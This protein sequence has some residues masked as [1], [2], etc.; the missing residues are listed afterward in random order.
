MNDIKEIKFT[1]WMRQWLKQL[2]FILLWSAIWGYGFLLFQQYTFDMMAYRLYDK[3]NIYLFSTIIYIITNVV[4][5]SGLYA[6]D[7][8]QIISHDI[9]K[10]SGL[11]RALMPSL[12]ALPFFILPV[13]MYSLLAL[14]GIAG[15][16]MFRTGCTIYGNFFC[17]TQNIS[18]KKIETCYFPFLLLIAALFVTCGFLIQKTAYDVM[19][20][21][22][23]DW[24]YFYESLR[25]TLEGRWF[26]TNILHINFL[27]SRFCPG[28]AILLPYVAVFK[29]PYAFFL[30]SSLILS[31]GGIIVFLLGKRMGFSP[32][33]SMVFGLTYYL[34]PGFFNMNLCS[35]YS[36]HE[37]YF[38]IPTVLL[39][40]YFYEGKKYFCAAVFF[41]FSMTFQETVP[42][43]WLGFGLVAL[44][45]KQWRLAAVLI[46]TSLCCYI[47]I[48]RLAI[49][50]FRGE[51]FYTSMFRYKHLGES[52]VEIAL[53]PI[54]KPNAFWGAL[55]RPG[56]F[57]FLAVLLLPVFILTLNNP[58]GLVAGLIVFVFLC[59]ES[60]NQTQN[61]M[62]HYQTMI[63]T[64]IILNTMY[65]YRRLRERYISPCFKM[66][67]WGIEPQPKGETICSGLLLSM[68]IFA[69]L[70]FFCF[71]QIPGSR[72]EKS[73]I[74][75]MY[76]CRDKLKEIA[77][78]IPEG[79]RITASQR[80]APHFAQ[81]Y[82]VFHDVSP[83][84]GSYPLQDY[85]AIDALDPYCP[86]ELREYLLKSDDF[87]LIYN[88]SIPGHHLML[89][90]RRND[91]SKP[92]H[93]LKLVDDA[94]WNSQG[95]PLTIDDN[96]FTCRVL[97]IKYG[98]QKIAR[99][100]LRLE[101]C[102]NY[103]V[104]MRIT[105]FNQSGKI[106]FTSLFGNGYAPAFS[107]VPGETYIM[108]A[109][110][111][112]S[113]GSPESVS[114]I[115]DKIPGFTADTNQQQREKH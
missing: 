49:P 21:C 108:D 97:F 109:K 59:I 82:E 84:T 13:K 115:I 61:I 34:I 107:A 100:M 12:L 86:G 55:L 6:I 104:V 56:T 15:L 67:L 92:P 38:I 39:S 2:P 93:P 23:S 63:L 57:Y 4:V 60:T 96:N 70:C 94:T 27:G 75:Q 99:F 33:E 103:D 40:F 7:V 31:S 112:D 35:G 28:L 78:L 46:I 68:P 29:S 74:W 9:P 87:R 53:S 81:E 17:A 32:L 113:F 44:F 90:Q 18:P 3:G 91:I 69:L 66:L 106:K 48:N 36:F 43:L 54:L 95:I 30:M 80:M 77:K 47:L 64:V 50:Y 8:H 14:L 24:G 42:V 45:R 83:L 25:N 19:Y 73:N 26:W 72:V 20:L 1:I 76:D 110:L 10:P 98:S 16:V 5:F 85:V 65:S 51:E 41:L 89:W 102:I 79:A 71:S 88:R 101:R 62:M 111:N 114:V 22:W 52:I 58:S 37:I 11:N 105:M